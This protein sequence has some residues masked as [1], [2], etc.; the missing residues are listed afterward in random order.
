MWILLTKSIASFGLHFL[1]D[2]QSYCNLETIT[3]KCDLVRLSKNDTIGD[4]MTQ[5]EM[6]IRHITANCVK[7]WGRTD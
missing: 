5:M 2:Y 1:D 7:G 3:P 4:A 6:V